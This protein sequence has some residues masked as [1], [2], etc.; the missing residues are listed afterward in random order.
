MQTEEILSI[1]SYSTRFT[2]EDLKRI[3]RNVLNKFI[4]ETTDSYRIELIFFASLGHNNQLTMMCVDRYPY[5]AGSFTEEFIEKNVEFFRTIA[6]KN[7]KAAIQVIADLDDP[8]LEKLAPELFEG[9][10]QKPLYIRRLSDAFIMNHEEET[11]KVLAK[12][13][14]VMRFVPKQLLINHPKEVMA[15]FRIDNNLLE[16]IPEEIQ[17]AYLE[18]IRKSV[19]ANPK[20][21]DYLCVKGRDKDLF[22]NV[23]SQRIPELDKEQRDLAYS[24]SLNNEYLLATLKPCMLDSKLVDVLGKKVI[25]RLLRYKDVVDAIDAIYNDKN[26]LDLFL[27]MMKLYSSTTY[28]EPKIEYICRA[29]VDNELTFVRDEKEEANYLMVMNPAD[30]KYRDVAPMYI[31]K[32]VSIGR[33][34][35][36]VGTILAKRELTDIERKRIAYLYLKN[37]GNI[38]VDNPDDFNNLDDYRLKKLQEKVA[39]PD[40][41]ISEAKDVLFE[42]KYGFSLTEVENLIYKYGLE[43]D[44]LLVELDK[45]NLSLLEVEFKGALLNLYQMRM[46]NELNDIN[47]LRDEIEN[48]FINYKGEESVYDSFLYLEDTLKRVYT[49]KL[50]EETD[51]DLHYSEVSYCVYEDVVPEH[52]R[53]PN[54]LGKRVRICK[55]DPESDYQILISVNEGYRKSKDNSDELSASEKWMSPKFNVNHAICTSM[56]GTDCFGTAPITYFDGTRKRIYRFK[57]GDGRAITA[58][59]PFDL[60]SNSAKNTTTAMRSSVYLTGKKNIEYIRHTHSETVVELDEVNGE[61]FS[62]R[63]PASMVCFEVVDIASLEAAIDFGI[64]IELIDRKKTA[65]F[66]RQQI[67][68]YFLQFEQFIL[69]DQ[70]EYRGSFSKMLS[71]FASMRA[72]FRISDL[73]NIM[74]EDEDALF[75]TNVLNRYFEKIFEDIDILINHGDFERIEGIVKAIRSAIDLE[76]EKIALVSSDGRRQNRIPYDKK[77]VMRELDRIERKCNLKKHTD[78]ITVQTLDNLDKDLSIANKHFNSRWKAFVLPEQKEY[79]DLKDKIDVN[80]IRNNIDSVYRSGLYTGFS[81]HDVSHIER[82]SVYASIIANSLG[83]PKDEVE[84]AILAA[85]YHDSGR[86]TEGEEKHGDYSAAIARPMLHGS[87]SKEDVNIICAAIDLHDEKMEDEPTISKMMI[88]YRI[89]NR[90]KLTRIFKILKDA[91]ALDRTRFLGKAALE[92]YFLRFE[93]TKEL[94]KFA[95][96]LNEIEALRKIEELVNKHIVSSKE[97]YA[98]LN[99]N[100]LPQNVIFTLAR[101]YKIP[102]NSPIFAVT[103]TYPG[104]GLELK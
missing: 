26:K 1:L 76:E 61:L 2:Y 41:T 69:N 67:H 18:E 100:S 54:Y 53:N 43:L 27:E 56:I 37:Q 30:R 81:S 33:L 55:V 48:A 97:A 32:H 38:F 75:N 52:L 51:R 68:E 79:A 101:K 96:Q 13:P 74:V 88:K 82:T 14:S 73:K 20:I 10:I 86:I 94:I 72:G 44:D 16:F 91:D 3:D 98:A 84:L 102:M 71:K 93:E 7:P 103:P 39:N 19:I 47:V 23:I 4:K 42:L 45:T 6:R 58:S 40:L 70:R 35:D 11:M 28:L 63:T 29:L 83:L 49:T 22:Y 57:V 59:A 85:I 25:E 104:V 62:K 9:L 80:F 77:M 50:V 31:T 95:T 8:L 24:Y 89:K 99:S 92:I 34:D 12:K 90:D 17:L 36:Y 21:Y 5:L 66:V 64:D 87:L 78:V 46:L 60:A 65:K 15:F